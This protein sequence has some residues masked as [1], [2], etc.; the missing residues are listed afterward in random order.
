ME[1]SKFDLG[2]NTRDQLRLLAI[3]AS[4]MKKEIKS[5][6]RLIDER[7]SPASNMITENFQLYKSCEFA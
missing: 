1:L 6:D 3:S 4:E 2:Y 7:A 5:V